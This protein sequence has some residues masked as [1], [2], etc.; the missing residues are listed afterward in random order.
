M[1]VGGGSRR[2]GRGVRG[3]VVCACVP[4][5]RKEKKEAL[6][7]ALGSQAPLPLHSRFRLLPRFRS[8]T[9]PTLLTSSNMSGKGAKGLSAGKGAKV[10]VWRGAGRGG[11]GG[12][13]AFRGLTGVGVKC[14]LT[15][16]HPLLFFRHAQ[17]TL[18]AGKGGPS[19]KAVSKSAKAGLQFPVGRVHRLLKV[20]AARERESKRGRE[21]SK[22]RAPGREG[23]HALAR[24]EARPCL[25]R[26]RPGAP[27]G[28]VLGVRAG[29]GGPSVGTLIGERWGRAGALSPPAP[30]RDTRASAPGMHRPPLLST[31]A[32]AGRPRAAPD[33]GGGEGFGGPAGAGMERARNAPPPPGRHDA[34][35]SA[36]RPE[37]VLS[38][39]RAPA[40]TAHTRTPFSPHPIP[41]GASR[42][43]AASALRR[44]S[45]PPPS[46]VRRGERKQQQKTRAGP[47]PP[48]GACALTTTLSGPLRTPSALS[49]SHALA[50]APLPPPPTPPHPTPHTHT[51][52]EYLTAE[53]LELAGNAS[54]DL[55]VRGR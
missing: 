38:R 2:E 41:R 26:E 9:H 45:T 43:T 13:R 7:L 47:L 24:T 19:K 54:K 33:G 44:P 31:P 12:A 52:A 50:L 3:G 30:K 27:A 40:L 55:K 34:A 46:W 32:F 10:C 53:V 35:N 36:R 15:H 42:P 37:T 14:A 39:A 1:C 17:G 21:Q 4:V 11:G 25:V 20:R 18:G 23:A 8:L 51:N 29:G 5:E 28:L 6:A 48:Y 49:R 16:P 22:C